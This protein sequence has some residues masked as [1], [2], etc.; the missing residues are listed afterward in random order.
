MNDYLITLEEKNLGDFYVEIFSQIN[1]YLL[2]LEGEEEG[3]MSKIIPCVLS[4]KKW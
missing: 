2:I 4:I 3:T 1:N